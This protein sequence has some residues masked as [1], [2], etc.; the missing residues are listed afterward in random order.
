MPSLFDEKPA[1]EILSVHEVSQRIK[2]SVETAFPSV[3]VRGEI[4]GLKKHSSGH[5]YFS[6]KDPAQDAVLNAICWR[7]TQTAVALV[8]GLEIVVV[9]RITTYPGRSNY[10]VIVSNAESTGQGALLKLL[11]ERK[12]KLL[13]EGLFDN[14]RPLPKF[15][16]IIGVVT[17]PTGAVFQD[18][19]HR[20]SDR[21]PCRIV[22]WPVAVQGATAAE[23]IA[24]AIVGMEQLEVKPD[25][26]IV[27]R[28]GGSIEDLW[29]FNEECVVRA[30]AHSKIPLISAVGHETDTTLIDYAADVRAPTPTAAAEMATPLRTQIVNDVNALAQRLA[31]AL[32]RKQESMS[33]Q[34]QT[35]RLPKFENL[36]T[37]KEMRLDDYAERLSRG[38]QIF[39]KSKSL[40]LERTRVPIPRSIIDAAKVRLPLVGQAMVRGLR[41][42]VDSVVFQLKNVA[43]RLQNSSYQTTLE[44]GFCLMTNLAGVPIKHTEDLLHACQVGQSVVSVHFNDGHLDVNISV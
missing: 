43:D 32:V 21:Y 16:Q 9:G 39:T 28:G 23:E 12:Q 1:P 10:Q 6:L 20:V 11:Q 19:K 4:S 36:L 38:L 3:K 26:I 22:L 44:R 17:S 24:A 41:T 15:P 14:K 31:N 33:L 8:D 25:V 40:H 7:G 18:I 2:R 34:L 5:T 42:K 29:P 35:R 27:A 13:A 37:Q 30:A